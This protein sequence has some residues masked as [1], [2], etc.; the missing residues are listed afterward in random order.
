MQ[1]A[2]KSC[3][4]R[5]RSFDGSDFYFWKRRR[6]ALDAYDGSPVLDIK[7]Y[8]PY[9]AVTELRAPERWMILSGSSSHKRHGDAV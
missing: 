7:P 3:I 1:L 6:S 4:G 2:R 5:P 8:N 9:D